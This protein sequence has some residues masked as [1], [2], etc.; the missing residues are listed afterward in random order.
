MSAATWAMW[1]R[2]KSGT[3]VSASTTRTPGRSITSMPCT[4]C[5]P[6]AA[7]AGCGSRWRYGFTSW[8]PGTT[9]TG[10]GWLAS[11]SPMVRHSD[12]RPLWVRSPFT[13]SSRAPHASAS[14]IAL[15]TQRTAC[16]TRAAGSFIVPKNPND[17]APMCRSLIVA[18]R[19]SSG[20]SSC[21]GVSTRTVVPS[22][23]IST[24]WTDPARS[25]SMSWTPGS[26]PRVRSARQVIC[27]VSGST[28]NSHGSPGRGITAVRAPQVSPERSSERVA[29]SFAER[30]M[31]AETLEM[32]LHRLRGLRDR[33]F[34]EEREHVLG[35][36]RLGESADAFGQAHDRVGGE[37]LAQRRPAPAYEVPRHRSEVAVHERAGEHER[38][39]LG[40]DLGQ[41][42][43][44]ELLERRAVAEPRQRVEVAKL[45]L[46]VVRG[47][48]PVEER[49]ELLGPAAVG[50]HVDRGGDECGIGGG[51]IR[52]VLRVQLP[53][54]FRDVVVR[55]HHA[56]QL[57]QR[58]AQLPLPVGLTTRGLPAHAVQCRRG[59]GPHDLLEPRS[60]VCV[61]DPVDGAERAGE[62]LPHRQV[63]VE[64]EAAG[65]LEELRHTGRALHGRG[66]RV[67][68]E[69]VALERAQLR[70]VRGELVA[71]RAPV[72]GAVEARPSRVEM[73]PFGIAG[74]RDLLLA[75][76]EQHSLVMAPA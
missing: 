30:D 9:A 4:R 75:L 33:M 38:R 11:S 14:R 3:V 42:E 68:D 57:E 55:A 20:P 67:V 35:D 52:E 31:H 28:E 37:P 43:V 32:L 23:P 15:S 8:L 47:A 41:R 27:A 76:G 59:E 69:V 10:T 51:R 18:T 70:Q 36:R 49:V 61:D 50:D 29:L 22:A 46:R 17:V 25:P 34:G 58:R 2:S 1:P 45:L 62:P 26:M 56:E 60:A 66:E 72:A 64:R 13:T 54:P 44:E 7:S 16:G 6:W 71:Q 24:C 19:H 21:G 12:S 63:G 39:V 5:N 53:G 40:A 73:H 74:E 48:E 65:E